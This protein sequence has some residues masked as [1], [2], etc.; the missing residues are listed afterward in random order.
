[1]T[2]YYNTG[3]LN[4]SS[5]GFDVGLLNLGNNDFG[6]GDTGILND[7]IPYSILGPSVGP[8]LGYTTSM[9]WQPGAPSGYNA[10]LLNI[11]GANLALSPK[12][13]VGGCRS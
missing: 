3:V 1:M 2:G 9:G 8:T 6:F 10:G 4:S 7:V 5:G 12:F 13:S 11:G